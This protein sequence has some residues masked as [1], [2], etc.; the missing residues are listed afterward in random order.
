VA[1]GVIITV[2]LFN[3]YGITTAAALL[4]TTTLAKYGA[5]ALLV[6]LAF[7][8]GDGS[9]EHFTPLTSGGVGFSA[10]AT[11]LIAIMW[12]YDGWADLAYVGGEVKDPERNLPRALLLGTTAIIVIYL[13]VNVAY[14][15]LLRLPEMGSHARSHRPRRTDPIRRNGRRPRPSSWFHVQQRAAR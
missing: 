5:L 14:L 11:A 13:S 12:T 4:N 6:G 1:A 8:A 7:V 15:Y 2:A 3:Y 10:M 9:A